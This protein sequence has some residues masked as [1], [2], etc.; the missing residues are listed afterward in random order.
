VNPGAILTSAKQTPFV[1][2]QPFSFFLFLD[3]LKAH[4]KN[5]VVG[6]LRTWLNAEWERLGKD[7]TGGAPNKRGLRSGKGPFTKD[8]MEVLAPNS[9]LEIHV[10]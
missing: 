9:K 1:S 4:P 8:S 7:V 3:S 5:K 10:V 2:K 6:T